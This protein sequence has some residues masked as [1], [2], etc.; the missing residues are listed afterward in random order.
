MSS[1]WIQLG[2]FAWVAVNFLLEDLAGDETSLVLDLGGA[3]T[4]IV[5][6][7]TPQAAAFFVH[8]D[9]SGFYHLVAAGGRKRGL[10]VHSFLGFGLYQARKHILS[11]G[12]STG[13]HPCM[14]AQRTGPFDESAARRAFDRYAESSRSIVPPSSF[15]N[16]CLVLFWIV[17]GV[18]NL[19]PLCCA[20]IRY[21]ETSTL[22]QACSIATCPSVLVGLVAG[23]W[24][25]GCIPT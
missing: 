24:A 11:V 16:W 21:G 9:Q 20:K 12:E 23:L 8:P 19:P 1:F 14:P 17:K 3:S 18:Y 15:I 7:L 6:E 5:F 10:F 25:W 22:M 13:P 4:Q 2:L